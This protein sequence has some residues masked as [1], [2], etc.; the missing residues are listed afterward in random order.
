MGI[1]RVKVLTL[2]GASLSLDLPS[3]ATL[4][5]FKSSL[6]T[7]SQIPPEGLR[8]VYSGKVLEDEGATLLSSGVT[9]GSSLV[10]FPRRGEVKKS[11][12]EASRKQTGPSNGAE[13]ERAPCKPKSASSSAAKQRALLA[14][15]RREDRGS[16][17]DDADN[18]ADD[19]GAA[20]DAE[21]VWQQIERVV[22]RAREA[23]NN[24]RSGADVDLDGGDDD[25]AGAGDVEVADLAEDDEDEDEEEGEEVDEWDEGVR[26]AHAQGGAGGSDSEDAPRETLLS[27]LLAAMRRVS[28]AGGAP[29]PRLVTIPPS[30][31]QAQQQQAGQQQQQA[32]QAQRPMEMNVEALQQLLEMGFP[33]TRARNALLM[34]RMN[35]Q[36][37]MERLFEHEG[38]P[39]F[40]TP[41]SPSNVPAQAPF[42]LFTIPLR[43][44]A[45]SGVTAPAGSA[46]AGVLAS[47]VQRTEP[48]QQQPV[49]PVVSQA[50]Q[51]SPAE[52][53]S[54][55]S[56]GSIRLADM[57]FSPEAVA[58]A[59]R[60]TGGDQETALALLL[61]GLSIDDSA[62]HTGDEEEDDGDDGEL[63][64][65]M[66]R[67][68]ENSVVQ[69]GLE[70]PRVAEAL[71][72]VMRD[73]SR[74]A[75]FESDPEVAVVLEQV[76]AI[77]GGSASEGQQ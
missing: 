1:L 56:S 51:P 9:D 66:Q 39:S 65:V 33:E 31:Q 71:S 75:E 42:Q 28:E 54:P 36:L 77:I 57:G 38:D 47:P 59:L 18:D 50:P 32:Q 64:L 61:S 55:A 29:A 15:L 44:A 6:H 22:Q 4:S 27:N 63:P 34:S 7:S 14:R 43:S 24:A 13:T 62:A 76:R 16:D 68:L 8:V 49:S 41:I 20:D 52:L 19:A 69:A 72:A 5:L 25:D 26:A 74:A 70:N 30:G 35:V 12:E 60:V 46:P 45:A 23:V 2:G 73:P 40:D 17:D 53:A 58:E 11:R 48:Q 21:R 10:I 37:A 67:V 3:D